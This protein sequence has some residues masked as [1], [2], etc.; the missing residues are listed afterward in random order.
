MLRVI[1]LGTGGALPTTNRNPSAIFINIKGHSMLFDCGE[2]AQQQMMRAKTGMTLESIFITHWHGDHFLG[3]PGLVQTMSFQGRKNPLTIFGPKNIDKFVSNILSLGYYRLNFDINVK[4]VKPG[5]IIEKDDYIIEVFEV[6][7]N[8]PSVGYILKEHER[9]GRFNVERARELGI[10]P[11]PLYSKLHSGETVFINGRKIE[12]D[13]VVGPKRSGRK[14]VYTGDTRPSDKVIVASENADLLIHDG[15][16]LDELS[17]W[18]LESK[19]STAI[20]AA[21]VAKKAGVKKLILMHIS[22]RYSDDPTPLL[23]EARSVFENTK[24]AKDLMVVEVP[25]SD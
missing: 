19:H 12:P 21:N 16:L 8:V 3:V 10:K 6:D 1:F 11:G 5:D 17:D 25:Y 2:G 14:V 20:E 13:E 23:K 18:A 7:H 15:M 9:P 24:M 22:S 4:E